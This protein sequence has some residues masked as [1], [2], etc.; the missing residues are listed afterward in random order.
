M[1]IGIVKELEAQ[2]YVVV[3]SCLNT[4]RYGI[5]Q[6]RQRAWIVAVHNRV[7]CNWQDRYKQL[8]SHLECKPHPVEA[9]TLSDNHAYIVNCME[10]K[11]NKKANAKAKAKSKAKPKNNSKSLIFDY[12]K[13]RR[14]LNIMVQT[15]AAAK[16]AEAVSALNALTPREHDMLNMVGDMSAAT[17]MNASLGLKH[18]ASRVLKQ[19][20]AVRDE[21]TCLLPSS[22]LLLLRRQPQRLLFGLETMHMQGLPVPVML[23]AAAAGV[24]DDRLFV[25]MAGNDFSSGPCA[26]VMFA[27]LATTTL[28]DA[29]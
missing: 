21:T 23:A 26:A 2:G 29:L 3:G 20:A 25:S 15:P 22:R 10:E 28:S 14:S 24:A 7:K 27:T 16:L 17:T 11:R 18:S 5:P 4:A 19:S 12:W 6:H 8:V 9:F 1:W 13:T